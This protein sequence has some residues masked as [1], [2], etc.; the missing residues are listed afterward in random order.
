[1]G[2]DERGEHLYKFVS[3]HRYQAGNDQQ[4]RNLLEEGTLYVAK[5]D[6]NENEL[7]GSGRWMEL[8]FGKNGLTPENG[9]KDQA[10]VLIFAR[11][12]AT[13][14]GAT[15]M[16]RPEW[17]AVHPDKKHVFCTLTNNKNRGKEGQPVGGPN[18][19]EKNNYGQIVRWMPAQGDHTSDVFAWD[20]YLIAGNPTVHKGNLY[21][22][23]E[24]ISADNMFNSP[25]GIGFDA[26]GRL[27]IQTDG[28]YSNQGDFAGQGNNQML[29]GDPITG[30]VKRFL[31]GPIACEITGLTF[32]PDHK[33]MFVGVQHPGEEAAPS[34]FPYGGTSKPRSTIMM[35]TREDGG[36]IGA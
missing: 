9:F 19:R 21:A 12:A 10:E 1:L 11:R 31:T 15:T 25:D 6:I 3:K 20:L 4:N 32:S 26:A 27:W 33:T 8:S 28:N 5:F 24:N 7:K 30:E 23:S 18:P 29:C 16:D 2:D 22:G 14:V 17:V 34:H 36:V 35:I 13:Q